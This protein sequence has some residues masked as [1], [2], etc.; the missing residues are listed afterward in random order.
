MT[1][2]HGRDRLGILGGGQLGLMLAREARRMG[3]RTVI[4]DPNPECPAVREADEFF[5]QPFTDRQTQKEFAARC[6]VAT[7]EFEHLPVSAVEAVEN[8]VE[9]LPGSR[10]LA[11]CQDRMK[12]KDMLRRAGFPLAEARHAHGLGELRDAVMQLGAPVVVKT[13]HAGYDGKGQSVLERG[14]DVGSFIR[15]FSD[16]HAAY[17]VERRVDL[18]AELSVVV[19]RG[20][21]GAMTCFPASR[22]EHRE[23]ILAVSVVPS[24]INASIL[25][26]AER[27][28]KAVAE[29]LGLIG[30]VCVEFF[31]DNAGRLMINELAPRPHNSGHYSLDACDV[32]QFEALV[33]VIVGLPVSPPRLLTPCAMLNVLGLSRS[34]RLAQEIAAVPGARLHWYGKRRSVARR[35][36]G[37]VTVLGETVD[38]IGRRVAEIEA[39][40][41]KAGETDAI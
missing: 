41:R 35:K 34:E 32:S 38:I 18:A 5:A 10:I 2:R 6:D 37:H 21:D 13:A 17:V 15:G 40:L 16:S 33:R 3:I 8:L 31:L 12:E 22:N 24:G 36:M 1:K 27:L 20:R 14:G 39:V 26:D 4:W 25:A 28:A 7:Y 9:V 23:N 19:A 29:T 11:I 30:I